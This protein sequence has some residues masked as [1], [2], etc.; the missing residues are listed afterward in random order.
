MQSEDQ[1]YLDEREAMRLQLE[2]FHR[3]RRISRLLLKVFGGV[4]I[5]LVSFFIS[6]TIIDSLNSDDVTAVEEVK[7]ALTKGVATPSGLHVYS[8]AASS[9]GGSA[10]GA[11]FDG[12]RAPGSFWESHV[13]PIDLI[14]L[15]PEPRKLTNYSLSAGEVSDRMPRDWTVRGSLDGQNWIDL[16]RERGVPNWKPDETRSYHLRSSGPV[17]VLRFRFEAGFNPEILRIYEIELG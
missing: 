16:S 1:E 11:A 9:N 10:V 6:L 8:P 17:Q 3:G 13:F 5:V 7:A 14:V 12:S 2:R 4:C 15:L